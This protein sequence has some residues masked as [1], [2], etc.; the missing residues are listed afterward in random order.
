MKRISQSRGEK[1][2][3]RGRAPGI[4]FE[5]IERGEEG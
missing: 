2:M 4:E 3:R 1:R 5:R